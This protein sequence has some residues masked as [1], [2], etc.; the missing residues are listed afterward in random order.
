MAEEGLKGKRFKNKFD[1]EYATVLKEWFNADY[2]IKFV[3]IIT[4]KSITEME[5]PL[6]LFLSQ[7]KSIEA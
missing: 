5:L 2:K 3:K 6:V 1:E 7:F 4:T